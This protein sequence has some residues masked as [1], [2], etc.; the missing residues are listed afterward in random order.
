[1]WPLGVR[2]GVR[3]RQLAGSPLGVPARCARS[4]PGPSNKR[5]LTSGLLEQ[6][7]LTP[8]MARSRNPLGTYCELVA[9]IGLNHPVHAPLC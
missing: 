8:H 5:V 2:R 3:G 9:G 4:R 6:L 7:R 1:M